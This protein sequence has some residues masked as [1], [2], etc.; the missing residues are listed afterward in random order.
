MDNLYTKFSSAFLLSVLCNF[1]HVPPTADWCT[2]RS[3]LRTL[4]T[5]ACS[6]YEIWTKLTLAT[7]DLSIEKTLDDLS[8]CVLYCSLSSS[9]P[10][11]TLNITVF[12]SSLLVRTRGSNA[13]L[14]CASDFWHCSLKLLAKSKRSTHSLHM[15][16]GSPSPLTTWKRHR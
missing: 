4:I 11:P 7:T 12:C 2:P 6:H 13:S 8:W 3:T 16:L 10:P 5:I 1:D 14:N 15:K 9:V